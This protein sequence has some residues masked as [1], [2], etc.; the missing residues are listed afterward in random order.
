MTTSARSRCCEAA[1]CYHVFSTT[2]D[3]ETRSK[4]PA[5]AATE[6]GSPLSDVAGAHHSASL[7]L[8][9]AVDPGLGPL[10]RSRARTS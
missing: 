6:P 9:S 7:P 5:H 8:T 2:G 3:G 1:S 4:L 10:R